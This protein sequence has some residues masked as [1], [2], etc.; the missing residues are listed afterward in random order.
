MVAFLIALWWAF[1]PFWIVFIIVD[2]LEAE[3]ARARRMK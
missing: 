3:S 2:F 1:L